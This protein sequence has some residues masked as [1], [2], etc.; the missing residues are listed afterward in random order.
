MAI[1]SNH[2]D[3]AFEDFLRSTGRPFVAIDESRRAQL[4]DVS[5][6][7][8]DF[9]VDGGECRLLIDV[10]GR[11]FPTS[12]RSGSRWE[13]WTDQDDVRS[14]IRWEEVFGPKFRAAFVFAYELMDPIWYEF[15]PQRWVYG[16]RSYSFYAVWVQEY[17][18]SMRVRSP[19]WQTVCLR[20][21][22]YAQLRQSWSEFVKP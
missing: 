13:C 15:H 16:G 11:R 10:K 17:S 6:K 22:D 12:G 2:Y 5:L 14:L 3:A 20:K 4:A 9:I 8:M 21:P 19:R 7:S 18:R 1:R